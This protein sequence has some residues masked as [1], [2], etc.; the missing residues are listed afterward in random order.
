MSTAG[1]QLSVIS[2]QLSV[3]GV[4]PAARES[5][6]VIEADKLTRIYQMGPTKVHALRGVSL[7]VAAGE[8]V[9]L[10]GPSGSGVEERTLKVGLRGDR[11][12]EILEG[13]S[14]GEQVVSE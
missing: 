3:I 6:W 7:K 14:E 1:D 2:S 11:Y 4:P 5:R 13:L 10:M 8:F 12:V 9:A